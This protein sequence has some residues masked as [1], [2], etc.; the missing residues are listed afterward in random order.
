ML[1]FWKTFSINC[2]ELRIIITV[3][4]MIEIPFFVNVSVDEAYVGL[5]QKLNRNQA[6]GQFGEEGYSSFS[7]RLV[8]G[9]YF[10]KL[11]Q[12]IFIMQLL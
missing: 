8:D 1:D 7:Y 6:V 3:S 11:L 9:L 5:F 2:G 12:M 4:R 10:L